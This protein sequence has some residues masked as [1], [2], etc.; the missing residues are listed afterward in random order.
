MQI[1]DTKLR[2]MI[3]EELTRADKA[4]IKKMIAERRA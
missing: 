3:R 4:E 2:E 1:T